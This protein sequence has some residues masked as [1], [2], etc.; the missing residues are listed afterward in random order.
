MD[1]ERLLG[2]LIRGAMRG[3]K[4]RNAVR[5]LTGGS[6]SFLNAST[7]LTAVGVG[8]GLYETMKPKTTV[9]ESSPGGQVP[10]PPGMASDLAVGSTPPLPS[11]NPPPIPDVSQEQSF[12]REAVPP[13]LLRLVRLTISAARADGEMSPEE[14]QRIRENARGAGAEH[15]VEWELSHPRALAEIV[16]GPLSEQQ[17]KDLYVLAFTI[18]R[19]DEGITG[20]EQI[21]LAQLA[22]LLTLDVRTTSELEQETEAKISEDPG[23]HSAT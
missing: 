21:Y 16:A 1:A 11:W 8:W 14:I 4:K 9:P 20:A 2:S 7:L 18:T 19:A 3:K 12:S 22:H 17:K 13:E 15:L 23:Q 6:S 10:G 5:F